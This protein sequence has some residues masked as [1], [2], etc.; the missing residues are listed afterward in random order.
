[1]V[2]LFDRLGVDSGLIVEDPEN[3][4]LVKSVRNL[5]N[6][7]YIAPE[8]VNVYDVLKYEAL[9]VTPA[10]AKKIEERLSR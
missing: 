8:G 7:K 3:T 2:E 5:P 4:T 10:T 1:M 6:A 9:V